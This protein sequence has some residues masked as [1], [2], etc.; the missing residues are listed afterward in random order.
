MPYDSTNRYKN[1]A[2]R[3]TEKWNF[4]LKCF[5]SKNSVDKFGNGWK[6]TAELIQK[7]NPKH[8]WNLAVRFVKTCY[9]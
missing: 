6:Q 8:Q 5:G 3:S 2:G 9:N 7:T 1:N 4:L